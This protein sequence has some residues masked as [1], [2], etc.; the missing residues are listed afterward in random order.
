MTVKWQHY[1]P[2]TY[3]KAWEIRVTSK[4]EPR[5]WFDGIYYYEK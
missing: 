5:K 3:L 4:K 1:V 2:Q